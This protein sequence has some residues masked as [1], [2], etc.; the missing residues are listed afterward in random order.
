MI[1]RISKSLAASLTASKQ[2]SGSGCSKSK[3]GNVKTWVG[4]DCFDSRREA[5]RWLTLRLLER[6]GEIADLERQVSY[7]L[8]VAGVKIG[9]IRPDFRYRRGDVLVVEDVKS[10][11]TMTPMFRWKAKHLAAEYGIKLELVL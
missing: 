11:P 4:G 9:T 10:K 3:F 1:A 6:A 8:T 5:E 7:D 2:S